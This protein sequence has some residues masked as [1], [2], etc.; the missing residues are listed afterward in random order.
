[1]KAAA[2]SFPTFAIVFLNRVTP[3]VAL[4]ES[5]TISSMLFVSGVRFS[6][7]GVSSLAASS[8]DLVQG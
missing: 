1:L 5:V 3:R 4:G 6:I 7:S 2:A 8:L